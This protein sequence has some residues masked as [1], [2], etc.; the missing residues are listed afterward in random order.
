V[1]D[2]T[3]SGDT[4]EKVQKIDARAMIPMNGVRSSLGRSDSLR[5]GNMVTGPTAGPSER[6]RFPYPL[7]V[8]RTLDHLVKKS[9]E[10]RQVDPKSTV[11]AACIQTTIEHRIVS[12]NHHEP[13][14][15]QTMH[16]VCR[17]RLGY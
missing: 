12:L 1:C 15:F 8:E 2:A 10:V 4:H 17:V 11:Q 16:V 13:L 9:Q 3:G 5:V 14:T 7:A 6:K